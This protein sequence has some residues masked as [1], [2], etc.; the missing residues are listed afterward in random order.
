MQVRR[1]EAFGAFVQFDDS[2]PQ[3]QHCHEPCHVLNTAGLVHISQLSTAR[4]E[5]V[6]DVVEVGDHVFVKVISLGV[7][8]AAV[9]FSS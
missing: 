6:T 5:A 7:R 8:A 9:P 3:G 4:A 2:R 1:V